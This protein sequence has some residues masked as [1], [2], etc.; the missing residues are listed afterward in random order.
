MFRKTILFLTL[1]YL[2]GIMAL[3]VLF[4]ITLYRV[5]SDEL[6]GLQRRQEIL[7]QY[8]E[9]PIFLPPQIAQINADRIA[10]L[11]QSRADIRLRLLEFNVVI[12]VLGGVASYFLAKKTLQPIQESMRMQSQF[13]ADASHELRTPLTAL[14][15]ELEV[16]LRDPKL[17]ASE[18]KELLKS[19]L[20]EVS[21]LVTLSNSLLKVAQHQ[22]REP[23]FK[24][25]SSVEIIDRAVK[26]LSKAAE[27]KKMSLETKADPFSFSADPD[28]LQEVLVILI[29]NALKY[30]TGG[31]PIM[32]TAS[33]ES[34]QA[35]IR[36]TN[37]GA[38][39]KEKDLPFVFDRFYR[40]DHSRSKSVVDG[41]GL[42]L[43]LA[44]QI[45]QAH[46][47][48]ISVTSKVDERTTFTV[49]LPLQ[50]TKHFLS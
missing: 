28:L 8:D 41:Y 16:A 34:R 40:A 33:Q 39:I 13:T 45:V 46:G 15:T 27:Q 9:D 20:E 14:K 10:Q 50:Q 17:A 37:H 4:S 12:F 26:L 49:Q 1:G 47:G 24:Q 44:K 21:K 19:N 25:V 38:G 36:I 43:Y 3:S 29:D 23:E 18:M 35:L 7:F 22:E 6:T 32:I 5:Y 30:G 31:Q 11:E 48:T 2:A 42:G